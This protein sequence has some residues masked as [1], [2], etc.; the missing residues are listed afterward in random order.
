MVHP[1]ELYMDGR[2]GTSLPLQTLMRLMGLEP[3]E[4]FGKA[5]HKIHE[6]GWSALSAASPEERS[7]YQEHLPEFR[8]YLEEL[9]VL[10]PFPDRDSFERL[11]AGEM[12][13]PGASARQ[14][15]ERLR[16]GIRA[17]IEGRLPNIGKITA[18][19]AHRR[20]PVGN[21]L[22]YLEDIVLNPQQCLERG[23]VLEGELMRHVWERVKVDY[24]GLLKYLRFAVVT[25]DMVPPE[26]LHGR[27]TNCSTLAAWWHL[28]P[29]PRRVA[30]TSIAPYGYRFWCEASQHFPECSWELIAPVPEEPLVVGAISEV[31][32]IVYNLAKANEL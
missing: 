21:E 28:N 10:R 2:G 25:T 16:P 12:V 3:L 32:K 7:R 5:A 17:I 11:Q 23:Y 29:N 18:L 31:G 15:C 9:G 20:R 6:A 1:K 14:V 19:A 13:W 30:I 27:P 22:E 24:N 4:A 8:P 26:A